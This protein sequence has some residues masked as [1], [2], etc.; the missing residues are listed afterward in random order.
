MEKKEYIKPNSKLVILA[1]QT[2]LAGSIEGGGLGE[3][4]GR[5]ESK[6][7]FDEWEDEEEEY[8]Y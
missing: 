6:Y 5:G 8:Y 4:G 1:G 7:I 2:L 3:K